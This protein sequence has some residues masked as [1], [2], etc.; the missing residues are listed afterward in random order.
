VN[1][2]YPRSL[3]G[4]SSKGAEAELGYFGRERNIDII[5]KTM[6]VPLQRVEAFG[7]NNY[8]LQKGS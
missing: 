5:T 1:K 3:S 2:P 6:H 8:T 7:K 4:F